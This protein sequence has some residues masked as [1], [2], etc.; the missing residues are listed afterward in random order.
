MRQ[1]QT[2]AGTGENDHML[3]HNIAGPNR[4]RR[5]LAPARSPQNLHQPLCR[6]AW[7]ILLCPMVHLNHIDVELT[8]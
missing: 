5:N 8:P 4:L 2:L 6:S 1:L 3:A 7:R